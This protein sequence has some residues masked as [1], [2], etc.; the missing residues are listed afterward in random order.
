MTSYRDLLKQREALE[1]QIGEARRREKSDA[2]A[3]ARTL[4]VEYDLTAH[5]VFPAGKI[6][7]SKFGRIGSK[8][9]PK[10]RDPV[11]GKTWTGRGK[12]PR[13]IQNEDREKFAI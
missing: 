1:Q 4:V 9:A 5:D 2:V 6:R 12:A 7:V 8:V 11:T 10:Y 13:W 3:Q